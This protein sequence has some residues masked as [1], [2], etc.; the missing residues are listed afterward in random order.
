MPNTMPKPELHVEGSKD[1]WH[2]LTG[3][4]CHLFAQ[5][6]IKKFGRKFFDEHY[7]TMS[8]KRLSDG[9]RYVRFWTKPRMY[10]QKPT[11][12]QLEFVIMTEPLLRMKHYYIEYTTCTK[13]TT[14]V[15]TYYNTA[16]GE[17]WELPRDQV[18]GNRKYYDE[19]L[20]PR[21]KPKL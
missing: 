18:Q 16:S 8:V 10:D 7:T 9:H 6:L 5:E 19:N 15:S 11:V 4:T 1:Y 2:A 14:Q 13:T 21:K 17:G 3:L 20:D 12:Y